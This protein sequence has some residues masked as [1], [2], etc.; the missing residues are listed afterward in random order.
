MTKT[1]KLLIS[2]PAM[3]NQ[4]TFSP[5]G[6]TIAFLSRGDGMSQPYLYNLELKQC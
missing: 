1:T 3:D 6:K 2:D 4:A 5:D